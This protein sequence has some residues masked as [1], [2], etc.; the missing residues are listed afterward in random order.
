M[1]V[2]Q[3]RRWAAVKVASEPATAASKK[4][5]AL[6]RAAEQKPISQS[7][8]RAPRGRRRRERPRRAFFSSSETVDARPEL[9][10]RFERPCGELSFLRPPVMTF[11]SEQSSNPCS[12]RLGMN[13]FRVGLLALTAC[14]Q[15][16]DS[17]LI[18]YTCAPDGGSSNRVVGDGCGWRNRQVLRVIEPVIHNAPWSSDGNLLAVNASLP[19]RPDQP[20]QHGIFPLPVRGRGPS[21]LAD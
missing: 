17:G 1:A 10:A 4:R 3:R 15:V 9:D 12:Q 19:A 13:C 2:G 11:S 16:Q 21:S 14:A 18:V 7:R 5:W 20:P 8:R 6:K